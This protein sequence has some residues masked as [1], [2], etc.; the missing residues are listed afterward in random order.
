MMPTKRVATQAYQNRNFG[1]ENGDSMHTCNYGVLRGHLPQNGGLGGS[2]GVY[3]PPV[4]R[5]YSLPPAPCSEERR[6]YY[7]QN[8]RGDTPKNSNNKQRR[9]SR[10]TRSQSRN[11]KGINAS[12]PQQIKNGRRLSMDSHMYPCN[13]GNRRRGGS[14]DPSPHVWEMTNT[15]NFEQHCGS[16]RNREN[17]PMYRGITE[18]CGGGASGYYHD[19]YRLK[20]REASPGYYGHQ[21]TVYGS[22]S[23]VYGRQ[24]P[25]YGHGQADS[26]YPYHVRPLSRDP[27]PHYGEGSGRMYR[28]L[29]RQRPSRNT[30]PHQYTRDKPLRHQKKNS[31]RPSSR[32]PSPNYGDFGYVRTVL[33]ERR[34]NKEHAQCQQSNIQCVNIK[35]RQ[36]TDMS[37]RTPEQGKCV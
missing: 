28:S 15:A 9:T 26:W 12:T 22:Q 6:R 23:L 37:R 20:S 31:S 32:D 29:P 1:E 30:S 19:Q 16:W 34:P 17:S 35:L 21:S 24:S 11:H 8:R 4:P 25:A 36:A 27:S 14:R 2:G 18:K 33:F 7:E 3:E 10:E 13:Q 5:R